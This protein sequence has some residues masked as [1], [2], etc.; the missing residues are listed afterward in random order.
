MISYFSRT[1]EIQGLLSQALRLCKPPMRQVFSM[2]PEP[3]QRDIRHMKRAAR[4]SLRTALSHLGP[5]PASRSGRTNRGD[6]FF[7][8]STRAFSEIQGIMARSLPPTSSIG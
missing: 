6:Q 1:N 3:S 7:S 8:L 4:S 5:D 2:V